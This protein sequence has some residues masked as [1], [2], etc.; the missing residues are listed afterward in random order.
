ML[1]WVKTHLVH[2]GLENPNFRC[3]I[4]ISVEKAEAL[5]KMTGLVNKLTSIENIA[6]GMQVAL[7]KEVVFSSLESCLQIQRRGW[8]FLHKFYNKVDLP[9]VQLTWTRL[10]RKANLHM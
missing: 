9:W 10:Y 2:K 7:I 6:F 1:D 8:Q 4:R 3:D 5:H